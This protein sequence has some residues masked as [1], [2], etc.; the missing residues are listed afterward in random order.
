MQKNTNQNKNNRRKRTFNPALIQVMKTTDDRTSI[1]NAIIFCLLLYQTVII[2][3]DSAKFF[4]YIEQY[5][6]GRELALL[7]EESGQRNSRD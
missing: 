4:V 6:E 2:S 3:L 1:N 5:L 7:R